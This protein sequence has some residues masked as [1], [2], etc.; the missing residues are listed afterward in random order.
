MP[1]IKADVAVIGGGMTGTV[2]ALSAAQSGKK[3]ILAS[4]GPGATPLSSGA[5]DICAGPVLGPRIGWKKMLDVES[6][7]SDMLIHHPRHPYGVVSMETTLEPS[8]VVIE[9]MNEA[10]DF[11]ARYLDAAGLVLMGAVSEQVAV[12]TAL[13]T[14]KLTSLYQSSQHAG[15][16]P[17]GSAVLGIKN[18]AFPDASFLAGMLDVTLETKGM[19]NGDKAESFEMDFGDHPW[20][21]PELYEYLSG[22]GRWDSFKTAVE[23][24]GGGQYG[25]LLLP[26]VIPYDVAAKGALNLKG[27]TTLREMIG[28]PTNAPGMRLDAALGK[29]LSN[30]DVNTIRGEALRFEAG[31]NDL[32]R[33]AVASGGEEILLEA[34]SWVLATGKFIGGGLHKGETFRECLL[35]LPVFCDGEPVGEVW[36]R[37]LL[38]S[39]MLDRH[40]AF[41]IGLLTDSSLRPMDADGG[42]IY[43]NL[44]AAGS[45]LGSYNYHYDGCGLGVCILT[46]RVAGLEASA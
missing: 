33:I 23:E 10:V 40:D 35:D 29:A 37:K 39:S 38:G 13:G 15:A 24:A 5:V 46:G 19:D 30:S 2:A 31:D 43:E 3:I 20:T 26:P 1:V 27:G 9:M 17:P 44:Y 14:W 25:L 4:K 34:D 36:I 32:A 8:A 12:P 21:V 16:L 45:V 42:V 28:M 7:I 18:M 22:P 11:L 41:S 6:N